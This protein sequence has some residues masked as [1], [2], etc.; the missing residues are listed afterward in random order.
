[1]RHDHRDPVWAAAAQAGEAGADAFWNE[2]R[3]YEPF[4]KYYGRC[5]AAAGIFLSNNYG[6][7]H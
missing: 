7:T 2:Y 5:P 1:M 6:E 3:L 4:I